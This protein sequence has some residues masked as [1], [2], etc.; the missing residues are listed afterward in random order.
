MAD[1]EKIPVASSNVEAIGYDEESQTLR[2]WFA[3]GSVYDY[4]NVP[5]MEYETLKTS[6]SIG[7]YL[8]RN[9]RGSYPYQ[10]IG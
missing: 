6:P 10:K 1:I 8:S 3:E 7:S 4:L 9:I 2:I 5:L